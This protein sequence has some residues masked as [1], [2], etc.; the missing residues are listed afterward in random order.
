MPLLLQRTT[1]RASTCHSREDT[2][3]TLIDSGVDDAQIVGMLDSLLHIQERERQVPTHPEF[4][5]LIEKI[6][7]RAHHSFGQVRGNLH[8]SSHTKESRAQ[9]SIPIQG[10]FLENINK[11]KS[12]WNYEHIKLLEENRKL[13]QDSLKRKFVR[14]FFLKNKEAI[15]SQRQDTRYF[16]RKRELS[17]PT[18]LYKT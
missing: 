15:Y 18:V 2:V 17:K 1:S 14:K 12:S 10:E 3:A 6:R 13:Y 7:R 9:S 16:C 11:F 4:I 8:R 5:T